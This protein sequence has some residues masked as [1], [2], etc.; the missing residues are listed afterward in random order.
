MKIILAPDSFKGSL[1]S[2]EVAAAMEIGVKR[3]WP[4]AECVKIPMADGGEG[5][6][7][8]LL[9]A[10]G[11]ELINCTVTG[12]AGQPVAAA[13]GLLAD[14]TTAVIEMA[15]A[16]GLALVDDTTRNP[17]LTTS[18][19]TGEL[20]Y[21]ALEQ[22]ARK[23]ILGIGGSAT[24]DAGVGMA[25][26]LGVVFRDGEGRALSANGAGGMLHNIEAVDMTGLHPALQQAQLLVACDVNNPLT[27]TDGAAY[28]FAPQK[29]ADAAMVQT[30]DANLKH[31]AG[32]LKRE[33]GVDVDKTPGAG[34]AGG[35]GAG[36][37]VFTGATLQR[38]IEI[39]SKATSIETHLRTADLV[40]TGE[41]RVDFQTAFGKTPA[42]IARLADAYE[43]PVVAIGGS[44]ADDAG[45]V[46]A[47]GIH[48]LEPAIARDMPLTDALTHA[49]DYIANAAERVIRLIKIGQTWRH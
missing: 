29:G 19:G 10:V 46:F 30:L 7:Q 40:L 1:T 28:M 47:H 2:M 36:L 3:V 8:S 43:V 42:G 41:G 24:N 48:G 9:D 27:G 31:L 18:Y 17:L 13:Y 49:R 5:T 25:Q 37:L 6:V 26:A 4:D 23:I 45:S 22:G 35:M 21:H 16:S 14:G 20:L 11:G 33:L 32:V 12:P 34:A 39:I 38:G 15:A 44:L